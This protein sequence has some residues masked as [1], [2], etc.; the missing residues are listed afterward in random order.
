MNY[1]GN[2]PSIVPSCEYALTSTSKVYR[3]DEAHTYRGIGGCEA[4]PSVSAAFLVETHPRSSRA[5]H[6][7]PAGTAVA[8]RPRRTERGLGAEQ[9]KK[10]DMKYVHIG[11]KYVDDYVSSRRH[12]APTF[13]VSEGRVQDHDDIWTRL[14]LSLD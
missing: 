2:R 3:T 5:Q 9:D 14:M 7:M 4:L 1:I 11:A 6:V 10:T 12:Q 8:Q 13:G